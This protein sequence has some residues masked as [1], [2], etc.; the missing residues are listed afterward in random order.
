[1]RKSTLL[2]LAGAAFMVLSAEQALAQCAPGAIGT[3]RQVEIDAT[4]APRFGHVQYP[5][6]DFLQPGE[7]VLTFDDGPHKQLTPVVLSALAQHCTKATFFMLGQRAMMYSD[8]VKEVAGRGHTIA[9]HTW[10]HANLRQQSAEGAIAEVELGISG[11]QKALG[12]AAAP[13]FRFPYLS[14]P[15]NAIGHLR[16]RNTAIFSIDVDSR[17]F[18]TR[19]PTV[20]MRNV[21]Q[22][23]QAKRRGIILFHDIQ[24]S[25]AGALGALL[26]D[27]KAGGY[28]VVHL[29]PARGQVTLAEFDRRVGTPTRT[30]AGLGVPVSNRSAVAPAWEPRVTARQG[31]PN[32]APHA[33]SGQPATSGPLL[34]A[35]QAAAARAAERP[36]RERAVSDDWRKTVFRE[37]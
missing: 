22:Q 5:G 9:T 6:P 8:L 12:R 7:I 30:V 20:V 15:P 26:T 4:G 35:Q 18:R 13:F 25:T 1:M 29:V 34:Q 32:E 2:S 23:L 11:V 24:P 10:S 33:V 21:M 27:L 31:G 36:A 17:D 28:R 14:D 37:W 16:S 19:S 3:S